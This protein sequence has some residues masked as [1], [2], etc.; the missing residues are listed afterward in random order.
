MA[1]AAW[2]TLTWG[3]T[4][5]VPRVTPKRESQARRTGDRELIADHAAIK[6]EGKEI[7]V[8][9]AADVTAALEFIVEDARGFVELGAFAQDGGELGDGDGDLEAVG[10]EAALFS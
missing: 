7:G 1:R 9:G 8:D 3:M 5:R 4:T 2:R 10:L 6:S